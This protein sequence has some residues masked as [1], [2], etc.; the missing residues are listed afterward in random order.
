[1]TR[2]RLLLVEDDEN[3]AALVTRALTGGGYELECVRVEDEVGMRRALAGAPFDVV[4]ADHSMPRFSSLG[5]LHVLQSLGVDVPFVIVSGSIPE[6]LAVSVMKA[7]AHDFL[8]KGKLA[9][10]VPVV[11]RELRD[12]ADRARRR[13]AERRLQEGEARYRQYF[14]DDLTGVALWAVDG[15]IIDCNPA[16][17]RVFGFASKGDAFGAKMGDLWPQASEH[18]ALLESV[19][20]GRLVE[21]FEGE[22]KRR[23]GRP[24]FVVANIVGVFSEARLTGLRGY[25]FD[26]TRRRE[27]E[28][29]LR[30]AQRMEAV[31]RLAG[32]VAHDFNNLLCAMSGYTEL[33]LEQTPAESPVRRYLLEV[34]KAAERATLLTRRL[35]AFSRKQVVQPEVLE[36]GAVIGDLENMLRRLIREDIA[37]RVTL[38]S[39]SGHVLAD[40]GQIEQVAMNL[41]VNARD[42]IPR[43]GAITMSTR[44]VGGPSSPLPDVDVPPGRYVLLTVTDDG[45][46]MT[47]EVRSHLFEPFFTT[48]LAGEGT[49]LGLATVYGI[50][51]Q[52]RAHIRVTTGVGLGTTFRV[53]WPLVD[54]PTV[55]IE[56][57][58][59]VP[60]V[61]KG[62]ETVLVVEDDPT[63][64]GVIREFLHA[65]GY[66][67]LEA[68]DGWEA[69]RQAGLYVG[70]IHALVTDVVMP[71]MHGPEVAETIRKSR[72][73]TRVMFMSAYANEL[74]Q[75]ER[76]SRLDAAFLSKPFRIQEFLGKLKGILRAYEGPVAAGVAST[77]G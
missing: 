15:R 11:E 20:K 44:V 39:A 14:E 16:F 26:V 72:P 25:F 17:V 47:P 48:K 2:L 68:A 29:Q 30:H 73:D 46:G 53:Y 43:D 59:P 74:A 34:R 19:R 36:L 57:S 42:A 10:L 75:G 56:A 3:D 23:D 77:R 18:E 65:S 64:R 4:I 32:G 58:P 70:P 60:P 61:D 38:D 7:G 24:V 5:A 55:R 35:L 33:T 52:A 71:G 62:T 41:V 12:A 50:V 45:T 13:D 1:M 22:L 66:H 31:G 27:L 21:G 9:R 69:V 8:T 76:F 67:V 63:V 37:L 6:D 51:E 40:R 54:T 49:G 28:E